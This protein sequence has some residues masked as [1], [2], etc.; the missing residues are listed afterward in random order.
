MR[1][2]SDPAARGSVSLAGFFSFVRPLQGSKVW[3]ILSGSVRTMRTGT[4]DRTLNTS[5]HSPAA[6]AANEPSDGLLLA[7][8]HQDGDETAFALLVQRHGPM[9]L[10]VCRRVLGD[11]P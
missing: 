3:L 10:S 5:R 11:S 2:V 6:P 9:V 4:G 1:G 8:F 7:R